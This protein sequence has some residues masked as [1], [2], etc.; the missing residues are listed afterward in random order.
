MYGSY[1]PSN[2]YLIL[3]VDL[4]IYPTFK[5]WF[6][7]SIS[8]CIILLLN[9]LCNSPI[10]MLFFMKNIE[11]I[12]FCKVL[13]KYLDFFFTDIIR[14]NSEISSQ[15]AITKNSIIIMIS[16]V[17]IESV[18]IWNNLTLLLLSCRLKSKIVF[19]KKKSYWNK[20]KGAFQYK[21]RIYCYIGFGFYCLISLNPWNKIMKILFKNKRNSSIW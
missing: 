15:I 20:N 7:M 18:M 21:S 5:I 11:Q 14:F 12:N 19:K 2:S 9:M 17:S 4:S 8:L 10:C 6:F 3:K 16:L 1:S 13:S